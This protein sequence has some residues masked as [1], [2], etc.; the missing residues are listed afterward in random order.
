MTT[1]AK[2]FDFPLTIR[3]ISGRRTVA[4]VRGK[5]D[6]EVATPPEFKGGVEGVWSPEDLLVAS[7]GSCFAVT[8]LAVAERRHVPVRGLEVDASG[9]VTRRKDG[10]F[11]FTEVALHVALDTETGFEEGAAEA[12]AAAEQGCLVASSLDFPMR[13]DLDVRIAPELA[14]A[15]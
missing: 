15:L 4:S 13:L 2:A 9:S 5:D 14:A 11:G 8:L 12:A 7:I 1:T 3:W 6:L 10:R